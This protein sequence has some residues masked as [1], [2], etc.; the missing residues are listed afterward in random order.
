[1]IWCPKF[2]INVSESFDC[3][4]CEHFTETDVLQ[5]NIRGYECSFEKVR[6]VSDEDQIG[7]A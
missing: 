7:G 2:K 5:G 3:S 6:Q 4:K 1:M